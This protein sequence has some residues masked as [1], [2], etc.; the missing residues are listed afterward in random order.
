M[1]ITQKGEMT[2]S[3]E[4]AQKILKFLLPEENFINEIL[5]EHFVLL[6]PREVLGGDFY[7]VTKKANKTIAV[8]ADCTGHGVPGALM[9]IFGIGLLDSIVQNQENPQAD[10]ILNQMREKIIRLNQNSDDENRDGMDMGVCI[11]DWEKERIEYA[12]ASISLILVRSTPEMPNELIE[13]LA[14]RSSLGINEQLSFNIHYIPIKNGDL[15]YMFSDGYCDQF[16]ITE[17]KK[18]KKS[19]LKK[20]LS[21]IYTMS[22]AEQKEFL[23]KTFEDWRGDLP[24]VDDVL[25]MGI[26]I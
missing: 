25:V 16:G 26:K 12:G 18:F 11:I 4:Y 5:N 2:E 9:S 23:R 17:L 8:V 20:A 21:E 1:D 10:L 7:W 15:V 6:M 13:I 3:I 24:Q 22:M 19:N 14:D